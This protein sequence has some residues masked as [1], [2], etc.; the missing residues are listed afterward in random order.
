MN[1]VLITLIVFAGIVILSLLIHF[2]KTTYI[3][4][5]KRCPECGGRYIVK[6]VEVHTNGK[7][8]YTRAGLFGFRTG[9]FYG[10]AVVYEKKIL[11]EN[12]GL[13]YKSKNK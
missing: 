12:C 6:K 5:K 9:V 2:C 10:K 11:C 8:S 1:E 7:H 3:K 13:E 4:K